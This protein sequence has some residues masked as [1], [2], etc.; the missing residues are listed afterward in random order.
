MCVFTCVCVVARTE[1][2]NRNT[3]G[4]REQT[5]ASNR[6]H[7]PHWT[8]SRVITPEII[9]EKKTDVTGHS[10]GHRPRPHLLAEAGQVQM[11]KER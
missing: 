4:Q 1:A 8:I 9:Q 2:Y 5:L 7:L 6:F 10:Q 11:A 3:D